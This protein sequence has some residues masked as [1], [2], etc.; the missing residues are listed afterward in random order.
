LAGERHEGLLRARHPS[1]DRGQGA[2]ERA[3]DRRQLQAVDVA[4]LEDRALRGCELAERRIDATTG[5]HQLGLAAERRLL[6]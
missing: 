5:L 6:W 4:E 3:G 1:L 2:A